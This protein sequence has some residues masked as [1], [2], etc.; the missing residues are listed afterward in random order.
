MT[1]LSCLKHFIREEFNRNG[2]CPIAFLK[3]CS[4]KFPNILFTLVFICFELSI[5]VQEISSHFIKF[6]KLSLV[7]G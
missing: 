7:F 6:T 5:S 4:G 3:K 1:E 2:I